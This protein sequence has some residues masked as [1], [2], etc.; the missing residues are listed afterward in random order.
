[1][2]D[3]LFYNT[4]DASQHA[5]IIGYNQETFAGIYSRQTAEHMIKEFKK[6]AAKQQLNLQIHMEEMNYGN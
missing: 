3:V 4:R 6:A 5:N 2:K 1:M